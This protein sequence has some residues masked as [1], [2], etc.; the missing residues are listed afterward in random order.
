MPQK[1]RGEVRE[2]GEKEEDALDLLPGDLRRIAE[3]AGLE[4]AVRIARAFRGCFLYV[5]GLDE[6]SRRARDSMIRRDY[7]SG[8][9]LRALARRHG[10]TTRRVRV[11]LSSSP[12]PDLPREILEV[13]EEE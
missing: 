12:P 9:T 11:I 5:P 10:L 3:V 4:A 2:A 6:V 1:G 13:L 7:D 8:A